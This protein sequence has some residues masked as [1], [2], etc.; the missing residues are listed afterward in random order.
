[1][2]TRGHDIP[3]AVE[4]DEPVKKRARPSFA[5]GPMESAVAQS[6]APYQPQS[7][8]RSVHVTRLGSGPARARVT[9][10]YVPSA[11]PPGFMTGQMPRPL[12]SIAEEDPNTTGTDSGGTGDDNL[13]STSIVNAAKSTP[14]NP[15]SA[16]AMRELWDID[17]QDWDYA[18]E[19]VLDEHG[20]TKDEGPAT[21]RKFYMSSDDPMS[22]FRS[23]SPAILDTFF[24]LEGV[25]PYSDCRTCKFR[26]AVAGEPSP[27]TRPKALFR[28]VSCGV[29]LECQACCLQRHMFTPLHRI[30]VC[31]MPYA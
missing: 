14:Y 3:P 2:Y 13:S 9:A 7:V 5:L 27:L 18:A 11:R 23:L 24:D 16:E 1:M 31:S 22:V 12:P 20:E 25:R 30:K 4:D 6:E 28:C 26:R 19:E 21:G 15:Q 10:G 29:F 17:E 8:H